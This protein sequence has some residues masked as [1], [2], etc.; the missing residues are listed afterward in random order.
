MPAKKDIT[1]YQFR[2]EYLISIAKDGEAW[3]AFIGNDLQDGVSG[4]GKSIPEAL[5]NLAERIQE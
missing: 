1:P 4:F 3:W 2:S 5:H